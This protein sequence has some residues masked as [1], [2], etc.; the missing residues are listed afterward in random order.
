MSL[1]DRYSAYETVVDPRLYPG[2]LGAACA[3][4]ARRNFEELTHDGTSVVPGGGASL[5]AHL[6]LS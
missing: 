3:A 2:R 5:R 1:T 6:E 4:H